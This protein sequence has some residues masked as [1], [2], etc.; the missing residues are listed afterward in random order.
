MPTSWYHRPALSL[1]NGSSTCAGGPAASP[2]VP[3]ASAC[4]GGPAASCSAR[5]RA[6]RP[7]CHPEY[8]GGGRR[9][10]LLLF[11]VS[12]DLLPKPGGRR[13][14]P[15]GTTGFSLCRRPRR[16]SSRPLP[17]TRP[18]NLSPHTHLP[19]RPAPAVAFQ[20]TDQ[21]TGRAPSPQCGKPNRPRHHSSPARVEEGACRGMPHPTHPF[22]TTPP[23]PPLPHPHRAE[24][25][26]HTPPSRTCPSP[27]A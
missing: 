8:A 12:G 1:S 19:T 16:R 17:L 14:L 13:R 4:V 22:P 24:R 7:P 20:G 23:A 10:S 11:G 21:P 2:P 3:Q 25:P 6:R 15:S 18:P 5:T 26:P 27:C 9:I